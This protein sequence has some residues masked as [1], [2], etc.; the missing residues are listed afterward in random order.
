MLF[1]TLP[2]TYAAFT[3]RWHGWYYYFVS[4]TEILHRENYLI[5]LHFNS[6]PPYAQEKRRNNLELDWAHN[7]RASGFLGL[8][9]LGSA[10][11]RAWAFQ[12][13]L[14]A[15]RALHYG[16]RFSRAFE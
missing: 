12:I 8:W 13:Y 3:H 14:L 16:Q 5:G 1:F 15:C 6:L 11:A 10:R 9:D 4:L 2:C 7:I